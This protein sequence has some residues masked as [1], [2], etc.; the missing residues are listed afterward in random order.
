MFYFLVV[1]SHSERS[2]WKRH[3][4]SGLASCGTLYVSDDEEIIVPLLSCIPCIWLWLCPS[5]ELKRLKNSPKV[6]RGC[7]WFFI[8]KE[9]VP[10]SSKRSAHSRY[11]PEILATSLDILKQLILSFIFGNDVISVTHELE[12]K[13]LPSEKCWDFQPLASKFVHF[14]TVFLMKWN[15]VEACLKSC[16]ILMPSHFIK[17]S[18][19]FWSGWIIFY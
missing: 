10:V 6:F 15:A 11:L 14:W 16:L 8:G 3:Q 19:D 9:R 12:S 17:L 13:R 1:H 4:S 5:Y 18:T 7:I 2:T